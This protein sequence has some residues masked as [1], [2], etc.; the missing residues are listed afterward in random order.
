M[1][2]NKSVPARKGAG[3]ITES[4]RKEGTMKHN[5]SSAAGPTIGV[6]G[7]AKPQLGT[8]VGQPETRPQKN[9]SIAEHT[10]A[11][12]RA[13]GVLCFRVSDM[14][15]CM[16]TND[17]TLPNQKKPSDRTER[18]TASLDPADFI[19]EEDEVA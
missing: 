15:A 11:A 16:P 12:V 13:L 5:K 14:L 1:N 19:H 10:I 6:D 17:S 9:G 4:F 3:R 8:N 7:S 18:W 2:H